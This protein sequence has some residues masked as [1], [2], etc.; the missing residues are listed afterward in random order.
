MEVSRQ[1]VP[2]DEKLQ[3]PNVV[4]SRPYRCCASQT[5]ASATYTDGSQHHGICQISLYMLDF[6]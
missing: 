6:A 2:F 5:K 4:G 3:S 1:S